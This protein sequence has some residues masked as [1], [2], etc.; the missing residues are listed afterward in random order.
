MNA[1]DLV[2]G[3]FE[4]FGAASIWLNVRQILKDRKTAG[5]SKVATGAFTCWGFWNLFYYPHLNQWFSLTGGAFIVAG[6]CT[7]LALMW[8]YRRN[9]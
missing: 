6:N 5:V 7:W 9:K 1:P 8:K 2:N 3:L 4:F